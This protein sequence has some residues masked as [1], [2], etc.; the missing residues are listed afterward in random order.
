MALTQ[1]N[2]D[3]ITNKVPN[4]MRAQHAITVQI[5]VFT[6]IRVLIY[7]LSM[8]KEVNWWIIKIGCQTNIVVA[9]TFKN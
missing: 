7:S 3:T 5:K 4:I 6:R 8:V 2:K 1:T 9:R